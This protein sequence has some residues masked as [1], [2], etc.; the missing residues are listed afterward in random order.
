M[1]GATDCEIEDFLDAGKHIGS[2][3]C[4]SA[5]NAFDQISTDCANREPQALQVFFSESSA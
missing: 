1:P 3:R 5:F 2:G 4:L